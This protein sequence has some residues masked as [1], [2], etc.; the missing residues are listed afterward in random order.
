MPALSHI[1]FYKLFNGELFLIP[2]SEIEA[3]DITIL[4]P[5]LA[6]GRH[7]L[8][9]SETYD[10]ETTIAGSTFIAT[11][12]GP[13]HPFI[14]VYVVMEAE[15]GRALTIS[16]PRALDI[17]LPACIVYHLV[18]QPFDPSVGRM[19]SLEITLAWA[20]VEQQTRVA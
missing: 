9:N 10:V 3:A 17:P 18:D 1:P 12:H 13:D 8:P 6:P 19:H 7:R 2:R 4:E 15:E 16:P 5:M 20:W 14:R 11:I